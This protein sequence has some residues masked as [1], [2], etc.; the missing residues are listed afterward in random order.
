MIEPLTCIVGMCLCVIRHGWFPSSYC[1]PHTEPVILN[2]SFLM[3]SIGR[4]SRQAAEEMLQLFLLVLSKE[5]KMAA[6]SADLSVQQASKGIVIHLTGTEGEWDSLDGNELIFSLDHSEDFLSRSLPKE[7]VIPAEDESGLKSQNFH[8]PL[9]P[10]SPDSL[11]NCSAAGPSFLSPGPSSPS[12]RPLASLVKSLSTELEP[13][14]G[15]TLRPKPFLSLV[16]SISTELS[17][18]EPEVS[19]SKSDSRLNLHLWKQLTQT[20]TRTCG[21]SRTAPPSPSSLSP[22]AEGLKGGFFKVELEDTKRKLSEAMH[23]PLSSMFSKIMG[24]ETGGTVA[25]Q[26]SCRSLWR[27]GSVDPVL[28][29]SPVRTARKAD[30]EV[31]P[32]FEWPSVR[33]LTGAQRRLCPVHHQR[34][35]HKEE[36]LEICTDGDMMQVFGVKT[37]RRSSASRAPLTK[38]SMFSPL[39]QP[40]RPLPCMSLFCV[41]VLSYGYFILPLSPYISGLALGLSLGFLLGLF[42][43]RIGSSGSDRLAPAHR[44]A[45]TLFG[46]AGFTGGF[47]STEPDTLKVFLLPSMLARKRVWNPKYPICIQL[48]RAGTSPED[49]EAG[50][51]KDLVSEPAAE[52]APSIR[53]TPPGHPKNAPVVLY[54]FGRTGREKEEW[55]RHFLLASMETEAEKERDGQRPGRSLTRPAQS[56]H[57]PRSRG[58]SRVGSSDEDA[59]STPPASC[60]PAAPSSTTRGL[61][62]HSYMS[63]ILAADE[64]TPLSSPGASSAETSPTIKANCTCD[65]LKSPETSQ[66]AW[67]NALIGRIFWDFLREKH[68]ADAVSHKIQ[69]KL[70]KIRLPYFMNELTLTE[71][72]M[73]C[74]MP[75]IVATSRPEVNHRGLWVELQLVYMGNLQMTLQTKFNLSKLGKEGAQDTAQCFT[76][77]GSL[78]C[79]PILSVLA[80]SD[81]E[82]S[83]AASSDEEELLL[84]EPHCPAWEK[85]STTASEG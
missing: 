76:E 82:S 40:P 43:I 25:H 67:A 17:R 6:S 57:V 7:R 3:C 50:S 30:G 68:W 62:Y 37:L 9:S 29:E 32:V 70:S 63:R 48:A 35:H 85:G 28:S 10:S 44:P 42:L 18:S 15:S 45:Q 51:V 61:D 58:L 27:D 39:P 11:G 80:D 41:A 31:L 13:K 14:E 8:V 79:R 22:S 24:E 78:S 64:M 73:G 83:S 20:K 84:S 71:L 66:T 53:Q 38:T 46:E 19:Q 12:Q 65:P 77:T 75:Q 59:P 33:Q 69:K 23:E 21:D 5:L 54:L 16:K 81:E 56:V 52:Q 4:V 1:R 26:S 72:D 60:I 34:Q 2:R 55:F 36:E 74:S 49:E 47:I